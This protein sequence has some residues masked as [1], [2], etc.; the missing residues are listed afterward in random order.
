MLLYVTV[1]LRSQEIKESLPD[2]YSLP[3]L[4]FHATKEANICGRHKDVDI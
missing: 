1:S 2:M 3:F 4:M